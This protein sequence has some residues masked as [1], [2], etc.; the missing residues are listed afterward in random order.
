MP[1]GYTFAVITIFCLSGFFNVML[2][3]TTRPML[4]LFGRR[5]AMSSDRAPSPLGSN[6]FRHETE[7]EFVGRPDASSPA[8]R[9]ALLGISNVPLSDI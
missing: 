7:L 3:F 1:P 6:Q 5:W 4:G 8:N 2:V 9:L